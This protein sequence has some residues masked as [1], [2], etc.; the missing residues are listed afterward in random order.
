M[1]VLVS[2][3]MRLSL[4]LLVPIT[5]DVLETCSDVCVRGHAELEY[6]AFARVRESEVWW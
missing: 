1:E 4:D 2:V 3:K 6:A 5:A